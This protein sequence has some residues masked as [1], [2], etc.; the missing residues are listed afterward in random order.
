MKTSQLVYLFYDFGR[1]RSLF[2]S[3]LKSHKLDF[4][5][6]QN[7]DENVLQI[8]CIFGANNKRIA[9]G[10]TNITVYSPTDKRH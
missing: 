4:M 8:E 5:A 3:V 6:T 1:R 7:A 2:S 10:N 9:S